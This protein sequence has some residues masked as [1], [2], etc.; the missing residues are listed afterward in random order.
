[1]EFA[2]ARYIK[3]SCILVIIPA[4][5]RLGIQITTM[6]H[7]SLYSSSFWQVGILAKIGSIR[8]HKRSGVD[9]EGS[10]VHEV[11]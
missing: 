4:Q 5:R 11:Q 6:D 9:F 10:L 8:V 7:P 2:S 1:M 3:S